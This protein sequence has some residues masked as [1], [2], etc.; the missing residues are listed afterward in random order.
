ME[1]LWL[2]DGASCGQVLLT[3]YWPHTDHDTAT[4]RT[5]RFDLR[6]RTHIKALRNCVPEDNL[7]IMASGT[8]RSA[9]E[10]DVTTREDDAKR[11]ESPGSG[12]DMKRG[13]K[14]RVS[15]SCSNTLTSHTSLLVSRRPSQLRHSKRTL[16]HCM[17]PLQTHNRLFETKRARLQLP[18]IQ[19]SL[20]RLCYN[21]APSRQ[22]VMD[23][24][25]TDDSPSTSWT[26]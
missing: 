4:N 5:R 20:V 11:R 26:P 10:A 2:F 1:A 12:K 8:K 13:P 23:G 19:A 9:D 6:C 21:L 18:L 15:F 17:S 22:E 16:S 24:K 14:V 25:V 7:N 3:C